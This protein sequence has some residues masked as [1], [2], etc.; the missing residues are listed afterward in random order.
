MI[1]L[2]IASTC[3]LPKRV[4][5][6]RVKGEWLSQGDVKSGR[7]VSSVRMGAVDACPKKRARSS[8][9]EGSAQ[10]RSSHTESTGFRSASSNSHAP[11]ASCV[12]R[13]C[14]WGVRA[15]GG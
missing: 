2:T 6:M 7:A 13:R 5:V 11:K 10:C 12:F 14:R 4:S 1:P 8:N 15:S 9:V 3:G